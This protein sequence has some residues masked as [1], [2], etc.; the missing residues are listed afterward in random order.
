MKIC[1]GLF[2]FLIL[3]SL[4]SVAA[5][6]TTYQ[7][8]VENNSALI[9]DG[10]IIARSE[11]TTSGILNGYSRKYSA[12]LDLP[13]QSYMSA[14]GQ[15]YCVYRELS[16]CEVEINQ[17]SLEYALPAFLATLLGDGQ[18][19]IEHQITAT[20]VLSAST[21]TLITNAVWKVCANTLPWLLT[22]YEIATDSYLYRSTVAY[23]LRTAQPG[24]LPQS[25]MVFRRLLSHRTC[26]DGYNSENSSNAINDHKTLLLD[27]FL[28]SNASCDWIRKRVKQ[29]GASKLPVFVSGLFS[30]AVL[31][32]VTVQSLADP[33]DAKVEVPT[34]LLVITFNTSEQVTYHLKLTPVAGRKTA[35]QTLRITLRSGYYCC[36]LNLQSE[37]VPR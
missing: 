33:D 11:V 31:A 37:S 7:W 30:E 12:A 36:T 1:H 25:V 15:D 32:Q 26:I 29:H 24:S 16:G 6:E 14:T 28:L 34:H 2:V 10:S 27:L 23:Q 20:Y 13:A 8:K 35:V 19:S 3:L 17:Q 18:R 5:K 21:K 22:A 4:Q 9:C